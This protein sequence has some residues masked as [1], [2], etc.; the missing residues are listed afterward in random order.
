L[1]AITGRTTDS[2]KE[3]HPVKNLE[4]YISGFMIVFGGVIFLLAYPM[5]YYGEYGPGPGLLPLW[6][7]GLIVVLAVINLFIALKKNNTHFADILPK[8][9]GLIN[10]VSCVGAYTLF[11]IVVPYLGFTIS[12]IAMLF[13]LFSR[14]YT[15]KKGLCLSILVTGILFFIFGSVLTVALPVNEFGW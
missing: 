6:T 1:R 9:T 8:G 15:W 12:S 13:I 2:V 4:V 10:V 3:G 5:E 11:I 7:S 14:G